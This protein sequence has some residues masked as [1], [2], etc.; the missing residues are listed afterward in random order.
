MDL[1]P[2]CGKGLTLT[3]PSSFSF[4][5]AKGPKVLPVHTIGQIQT[6]KGMGGF[7]GVV[8]TGRVSASVGAGFHGNVTRSMALASSLSCMSQRN[9]ARLLSYLFGGGGLV[10]AGLSITFKSMLN[11]IISLSVLIGA[12]ALVVGSIKI[13]NEFFAKHSRPNRNFSLG[14]DGPST[15]VT[16]PSAT[17]FNTIKV[18]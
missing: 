14:F 12:Y 11:A 16:Q 18:P 1:L 4:A 3:F 7:R 10:I 5:R 8:R 9:S 6:M 17:T 2:P 15:V 13:L